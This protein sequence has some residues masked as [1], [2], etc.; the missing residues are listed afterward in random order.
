MLR[1]PLP[2]AMLDVLTSDLNTAAQSIVTIPFELFRLQDL[3][4][5]GSRRSAAGVG[6]YGTF[7]GNLS[8]NHTLTKENAP[9]QTERTSIRLDHVCVDPNGKPVT[10]SGYFVAVN[11]IGSST[12][13]PTPAS[14]L[15]RQLAMFALFGGLAS[16]TSPTW[17]ADTASDITRVLAGEP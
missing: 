5:T 4:P 11:P 8:I 6:D 13:V 15:I 10:S 2:I 17:D 16:T 12:F 14:R 9:Y 1:D 3:T 7:R